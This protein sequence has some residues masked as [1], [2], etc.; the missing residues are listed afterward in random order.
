[1]AN[2][3]NYEIRGTNRVKNQ[4]RTLI[5]MYPSL[6][7]PIIKRHAQS[8]KK[9][10]RNTEYPPQRPLQTYIR[11]K[12]FGGIAGSFGVIQKK[13]G[14]YGVRNSR[15]YAGFVIGKKQAWMHKGRWW[16]MQDEVQSRVHIL[17]KNLT[18]FAEEKL[19][20]AND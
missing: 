5:A 13:Q 12:F 8:E 6:V 16:I 15:P 10:L 4:L 7:D 18:K 2:T 14:V 20:N 9:E 3:V 19:N 11:K 17:T 1:M